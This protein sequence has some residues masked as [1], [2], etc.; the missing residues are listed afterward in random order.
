MQY[1]GWSYR[2]F[3][4]CPRYVIDL[5]FEKMRIESE[6]KTDKIES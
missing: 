3:L 2:D 5:I 4:D 6:K 1:M